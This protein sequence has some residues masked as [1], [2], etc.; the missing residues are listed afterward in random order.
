G[1]TLPDHPL[2][3]HVIKP[4]GQVL[5]S[6]VS[7]PQNGLYHFT[8]PLVSNAA[9]GMW[10]I[11]A[12]TG[13]NQYRMWDYHV[14]DFMP[15]RMALN[16]TGEKTPLTPKDEVRFSLVGYYLYVAP[17]KGNTFQG[18]LFIRPL[19]QDL[20]DIPGFEFGDIAPE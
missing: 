5:R 14:E 10:H 3:L 13:D 8:W 17:A 12:N 11:R 18:Q 7:Q 6:V 1:K 20:S 15:E 2:K 19:R 9:I 16:L 4:D